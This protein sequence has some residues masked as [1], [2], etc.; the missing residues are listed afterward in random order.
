MTTDEKTL[1]EF[2]EE[3][4]QLREKLAALE[5]IRE[6]ARLLGGRC[7]IRSKPGKGTSVAVELPLVE[8]QV[9]T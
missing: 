3:V 4:T 2:L 6:R 8:A 9:E 1:A 7:R 5:G